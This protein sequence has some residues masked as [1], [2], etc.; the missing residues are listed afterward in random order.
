[1]TVSTTTT[2]AIYNGDGSATAFPTTFEFFDDTDIEVI[3]R[4]V[5]TG[6]ETVKTLSTDYTVSGGNG[7]T[8]TVNA[9]TAPAST[10]QWAIRRKTPLTQQIDYV[11]NDDFPAETHEQGLDRGVMIAQERQEELDRALKF[12]VSDAASLDPEIPNS[13]DRASKFLGFD[14][15]GDSIATAGSVDTIAVSTFMQTVVDDADAAAARATLGAGVL[16][17]IVEDTT[18][19]LGGVLDTN[20]KAIDESEGTTVASAATTNIWA[21]DGNTVH[22]TGTVTITSFGTAPRAGAWR[23]V[24]FDGVLTLTKISD[25]ASLDPEI[26]NSVDRASKFLGFDAS[27]DSIATAGSVDTIAV[28]TFMQ[29]VVDDADAAAARATLGAGVL[30]NIV[31]DTTPQLGGVLDTNA[32]AIDESEGTTVA[33]AA[34][35]NIWATD[36]NT[37]HITGTVTITSFGTAPR[38][39]A[40]RK[41]IFD[42]V[43]TL[44]NGANLALQGGANITTS[45][46]DYAFVHANTT[47]QFDVLYF[48]KDG[49]AVVE[50]TSG[51][52]QATQAAIEAETNED[53]YLPPDLIKHSPGVPKGWVTADT[54]GSFSGSY[55][56]S[57]IT[58]VGT[59]IIRVNWTVAFSDANY[60]VVAT[61]RNDAARI[62][63][64]DQS[65]GPTT[66]TVQIDIYGTS[67]SKIDPNNTF[68]A[69]F[70]DQ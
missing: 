69:A 4:A 55:N 23:K 51:P 2:K 50:P 43:L 42:G 28:S 58:D 54:I 21:T 61:A 7:A 52:S 6:A 1:M 31:E 33:S 49:T 36:G 48:K 26:P 27:G 24:I 67:G 29:T 25:A 68:V 57:S 12:P 39:G 17:N 10:V 45:A 56:V 16:D 46:G 44:T 63:T 53:T 35:T 38:A 34:T 70:G 59:G 32:K 40:W 30:D 60:T 62:C 14:A 9:V 11:E 3:E 18:P 64:V 22:I 41:V 8:G 13:V 37:V 65:P 5:S 15:S 20:A 47:T 19:Q 66:T